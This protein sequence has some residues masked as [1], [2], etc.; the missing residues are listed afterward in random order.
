MFCFVNS[1]AQTGLNFQGVARNSNNVILA[2]QQISLRLSILQGSATGTAEYTETRIVSTNAQGLFTVVIGEVGATST[3]GNFTTIN[4]KNTPKYLKIEMDAAAGNNFITMGTTQF[5][6]VAYAQFANSVD[7]EN[8]IGIVPVARGGTGASSLTALKTALAIDKTTV[9][10]ANVDNTS[11]FLKPINIATQTALNLKV[12]ASD[13]V[14]SLASKL[15]KTD[16]SYLLQKADTISLSNRIALK[17]NTADVTTGLLLKASVSD[18]TTGLLTKVDKVTGKDLSSN[19]FTYSEKTKL[20]SIS[21]TNTGD[22]DLSTLA[23][24][25]ALTLKANAAD[26]TAGFALKENES[27]KSTASDLGGTSPSNVLYPTQKAVKE[28]VTANAASGSVADG[29]ITN[30]KLADGS[31][32]DTKITSVSGS[33]VIGNILGNAA[34]VSTNANLT[35]VVTSIGNATSIANGVITNPMLSNTAVANLSGLNTGD[36]TDASIKS[37]L[38]VT[39]FFSGAYTDLTNKPDLTLKENASNKTIDFIRD[40][41]SDI[42]FP[43]VKA[44]KGYVDA[45]NAT[46]SNGVVSLTTNQPID[47]QKIFQNNLVMGN[48]GGIAGTSSPTSIN[49]ANGSKIGDIQNIDEGAPDNLGSIDLYAPDKSKWVQL[50]YGNQNYISL[51]N[52][53]AYI[54]IGE[55]EWNFLNNGVTE[56]P[57]DLNFKNYD[58]SNINSDNELNISSKDI[59][60]LRHD[61]GSSYTR[62]GLYEDEARLLIENE[63]LSNEW[64]YKV[65][66]SSWFPGDLNFTDNHFI[67][68]ISTGTSTPTTNAS[69]TSTGPFLKIQTR[70][71]TPDDDTDAENGISLEYENFNNL[72][73]NSSGVQLSTWNINNRS[74]SFVDLNESSFNFFSNDNSNN[75]NRWYF[76]GADA[77]TNLPGKL[78]VAQK[79]FDDFGLSIT[80]PSPIKDPSLDRDKLGSTIGL[81]SNIS[82]STSSNTAFIQLNPQGEMVFKTLQQSMS[83]ENDG[84]GDIQFKFKIPEGQTDPSNRNTKTTMFINNDNVSIDGSLTIGSTNYPKSGGAVGQVLTIGNDGNN[85]IWATP[86]NTFSNT[87]GITAINGITSGTH[88]LTVGANGTEFTIINTSDG[89]HIFNIPISSTS[90]VQA[91]LLSNSDWHTFNNKQE[92]L[93]NAITGTSSGTF[94]RTNGLLSFYDGENSITGDSKLFWDGNNKRLG[95]GTQT[96]SSPVEINAGADNYG[97]MI[98]SES[99]NTWGSGIGFKSSRDAIPKTGLFQLDADGSMVFRTMQE[100]MY[101]DNAGTGSIKFRMGDPNTSNIGMSLN[102]SGNLEVTGT[103]KTGAVVYPKVVGNDGDVLTFDSRTNKAVWMAPTNTSISA[104]VEASTLSGTTLN[105]TITG[106]SLTSV[107]TIANLT[108]GAI[109]NSGKLIV[110]ASSAASSSAVFEASSTTQGF[111][112]PRMSF[113]QRTQ[114]T[115][116]V[117]GLTIWCSNCGASGEMQVFNGGVWTNMIGGTTT[118]T[119]SLSIGQSYQGGKVAYILQFGDPGYD[120]NTQHGLIAAASDQSSGIQWFNGDYSNTGATATAICSGLVN[121]NI[122]IASQGVTSI[123]YAAGLARAYNGGGYNDWYLP[124]KDELNK[125]YQNR[126]AIGGFSVNTY[127]S[128]TELSNAYAFVQ[129][130]FDGN[131]FNL[132]KHPAEYVRA[133]RSF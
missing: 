104:N 43:T 80:S 124:S 68:F 115:S 96:P 47:G 62:L 110:G 111:L 57:G 102:N 11:D 69:I 31:V 34:S 95:I 21:G 30:I 45:A 4:W 67:N 123:N 100:G 28:Y 55:F 46:L 89:D 29:G 8:I 66:G 36:E 74:Y 42:K 56:L 87:T 112:P 125:L 23:T 133:I 2:S 97:L 86:T 49:F 121:T 3:T 101:F 132:L 116:P 73:I 1:Y 44:V 59:V 63:A 15:N 14:S 20:A 33:K 54:Y 39:S 53:G 109:T 77:S 117:A 107:G 119:L 6:Y 65:D 83:F 126:V 128:S 50:N 9:G 12:N 32:T 84:V 60:K 58:G 13:L 120:A 113:Y 122:I 118:A 90:G 51:D 92:P 64:K 78:N 75:Q 71:L 108:T 38:G 88:S 61:N 41:A 81:I 72:K 94:N 79:T 130:F 129:D 82:S 52:S 5:Q 70:A 48:F 76:N 93:I 85:A 40:A 114:I 127:W 105:T 19:D 27:N 98:S 26:V 99:A 35:G 16:T 91:G 17:A 10:L 18:L 24:I 25:T 131:Q 103:L 37:K 106:S 22:Q 7:A